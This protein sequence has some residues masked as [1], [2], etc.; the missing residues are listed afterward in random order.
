MFENNHDNLT[1]WLLD[2]EAMKPGN[3]M[4]TTL[5]NLKPQGLTTDE[6]AALTAYLESLR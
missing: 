5:R 3:I 6:V 4:A 1:R 2:P